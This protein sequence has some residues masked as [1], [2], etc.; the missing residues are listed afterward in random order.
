M[1]EERGAYV[2]Q[3][4]IDAVLSRVE[5]LT[6]KNDT[7]IIS[8]AGG[9]GSGKTEIMSAAI[10]KRF[11]EVATLSADDY[12][13]ARSDI[14]ADAASGIEINFDHPRSVRLELLEE[15]LELL[16]SGA[17]FDKPIFSFKEQKP[18][19]TEKFEPKKIV[20]LEGLFALFDNLA[21]Q[22]HLKIF[23]EADYPTRFLRRVSRDVYRTSWSNEEILSYATTIVEP[24]YKEHVEPTKR[25]ADI[26]VVNN[27]VYNAELRNIK[28]NVRLK[29]VNLGVYLKDYGYVLER[30]GQMESESSVDYDTLLK[31]AAEDGILVVCVSGVISE[32]EKILLVRRLPNDTFGGLYEIPG[33]KIEKGEGVREALVRE[34]KEETGLRVIKISRYLGSF[35]Y[36][37][38]S[39]KPVR[40]LNF[41]VVTEKGEIVLSEHDDYVWVGKEELQ[42]YAQ[43]DIPNE[44]LKLYNSILPFWE[45]Q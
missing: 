30:L 2:L 18:I 4:G 15:H 44:E 13:R 11:G 20:V 34:I 12:I 17:P 3:E 10:K 38:M 6:L 43:R 36:K 8:I 16:K 9:S 22:S 24:M 29:G 45:N 28:E 5:A 23:M 26:V 32:G 35:D 39:R 25:N 31:K 19:G 33:G 7:S 27:Y 21:R 40:Q 41:A 14:E 42:K 1:V 37:G